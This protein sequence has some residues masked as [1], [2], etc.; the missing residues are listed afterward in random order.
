MKRN[1]YFVFTCLLVALSVAGQNSYTPNVV[2]KMKLELP[3]VATDYLIRSSL[4]SE[5]PVDYTKGVFIV[6]ED[7]YGHNNSTVNFI[8]ENGE[9]VYRVFQKENPGS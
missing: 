6:N 2:E 7:W 5:T 1:I 3:H 9:W 8:T 4:R